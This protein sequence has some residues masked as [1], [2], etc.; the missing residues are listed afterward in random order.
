MNERGERKFPHLINSKEKGGGGGWRKDRGKRGKAAK[1]FIDFRPIKKKE[2][3]G[4]ELKRKGGARAALQLAIWKNRA[5]CIGT[6]RKK[7]E[8]GGIV[9]KEGRGG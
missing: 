2:A 3:G 8:Q 6:K 4:R 1:L 5:G 7:R 9:E